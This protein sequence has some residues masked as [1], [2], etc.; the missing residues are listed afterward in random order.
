LFVFVSDNGGDQPNHTNK[1]NICSDDEWNMN[2]PLRGGKYSWWEGGVRTLGF[3]YSETHLTADRRGA[4]L[5]DL[6]SLADWCVATVAR[7]HL[8][9]RR[10]PTLLRAAG[11]ADSP[12]LP[13][14]VDQWDAIRGVATTPAREGIIHQYWQ[15]LG[16]YAVVKRINGTLWKMIRGWPA[17]GFLLGTNGPIV[18][19]LSSL[20]WVEQPPE[21]PPAES[22][23]SIISHNEAFN[24]MPGCLFDVSNDESETANLFPKFPGI[25]RELNAL[26]FN[27]SARYRTTLASGVCQGQLWTPMPILEPTD[28]KAWAMA[29]ACGAY[30]PW[31]PGSNAAK[32]RCVHI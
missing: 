27:A 6:V 14:A 12:A 17:V 16:R 21:L 24:C 9:D 11:L 23:L 10:R 3:V 25:V 15:E 22:D 1:Q 18:S 32:L 30:V 8:R 13:D 31:L 19:G 28:S 5:E 26:A 29:D 2:Y 20:G 7:T 4:T